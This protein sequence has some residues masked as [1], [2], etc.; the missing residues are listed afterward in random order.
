[1]TPL[2]FSDYRIIS[3]ATVVKFSTNKKAYNRTARAEARGTYKPL[4]Q[5]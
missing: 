3:L 5:Y 4:L 1:M 2:R